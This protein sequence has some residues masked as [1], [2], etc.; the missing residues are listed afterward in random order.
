[1]RRVVVAV[2]IALLAA[3]CSPLERQLAIL[4]SDAFD[5]R[6]NGTAGSMRTQ[7]YLLGELDDISAPVGGSFQ[8]PF[9]QGTNL[10]GLIRGT[11]LPEEYVI[12][13]AHFDHVGHG[14]RSSEPDDVICNGATD[15]A[16]GVAAVL[17]I[18]RRLAASPPRRS[19]VLALWDAEEDGLVGSK[20]YVAAPAIPLASTVAY[21]N[22]DVYGADLL[23]SL[24]RLTVMVG[25]ETGGPTLVDAATRAAEG[26]A[27][28][29]PV[30]LSLLFGQGRSDHAVFADAGVPTVFFTDATNGCYH[31]A[32]DELGAV[33]VGKLEHEIDLGEA[34]ARD[35]AGT[36]TPPV[37][38]GN[39]PAA[40]Y[41][42]AVSMLAVMHAAEP[43]F[44]LLP[45]DTEP[46]MAAYLDALEVMVADGRAAFDDDDVGTLLAGAVEL[47]LGLADVDCDALTG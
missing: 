20:A 9:A 17:E 8:H 40:T 28:V 35:L 32:Q 4:S 21:L 24:A 43:D 37:H 39:N 19:V 27:A 18:G 26:A 23:P 11:D 33:D 6:D 44:G 34:L 45:D 7:A 47:V 46:K 36:D 25:A 14:C 3:A 13:G 10:L 41:D 15:N 38:D 29:D 42:D 1:M 30:L 16:A 22:W 31:T 12:L 5:G 2:A